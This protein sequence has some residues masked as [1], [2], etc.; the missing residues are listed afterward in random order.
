MPSRPL[1]ADTQAVVK[2]FTRLDN[3]AIDVARDRADMPT[4]VARL[5][6]SWY[7]PRAELCDEVMARIDRRPVKP[8][9][10]PAAAS[11]GGPA[12]WPGR[13][14]ALL[15]KPATRAV[16]K[17]F[18]R[19]DNEAIDIARGRTEMPA[20]MPR[21]VRLVPP[22]RIDPVGEVRVRFGRGDLSP[23]LDWLPVHQ[24][25][26][27]AHRGEVGAPWIFPLPLAGRCAQPLFRMTPARET[28][29]ALRRRSCASPMT[30]SRESVLGV[31]GRARP[32]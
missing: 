2:L 6:R 18:T 30:A 10:V 24:V 31:A 13:C 16:V 5:A 26:Q 21:L 15:T 25:H 7:R 27:L 4:A 9:G 22:A 14:Y 32:A 11:A 1:S 29:V 20:A 23:T 12:A 3:E 17:P 19:L 8:P 28:S